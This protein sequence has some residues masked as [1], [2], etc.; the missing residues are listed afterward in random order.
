MVSY[1]KLK[2]GVIRATLAVA[3]IWGAHLSMRA[4][5]KKDGNE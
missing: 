2:L 3:C 1:L 4:I 5:G